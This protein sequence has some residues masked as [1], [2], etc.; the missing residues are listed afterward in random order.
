MPSCTRSES[1]QRCLKAVHKLLH[2]QRE[3]WAA[4]QTFLMETGLWGWNVVYFLAYRNKAATG[5]FSALKWIFICVQ[6]TFPSP[7]C[8]VHEQKEEKAEFVCTWMW[9]VMQVCSL[10]CCEIIFRME[11]NFWS[12]LLPYKKRRN[13][14][15][16]KMEM[17]METVYSNSHSDSWCVCMLTGLCTV[18][19]I[20]TA[21][22]TL[23]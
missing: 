11:K 2:D 14:F 16:T 10:S 19:F 8:T 4:T 21:F 15:L 9:F 6:G 5:S 3:E 12:R 22:L 17:E 23:H 1:L 7:R 18:V 13:I 20:T